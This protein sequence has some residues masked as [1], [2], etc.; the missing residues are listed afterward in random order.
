MKMKLDKKKKFFKKVIR[1]K[2]YTLLKKFEFS[3]YYIEKSIFNYN[4]V[5]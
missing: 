1:Q 5:F 2:S 3:I 4:F